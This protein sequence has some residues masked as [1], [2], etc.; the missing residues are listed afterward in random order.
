MPLR[1]GYEWFTM[2]MTGDLQGCWYTRSEPIPEIKDNEQPSGIYQ[3]R[4]EEMFVEYEY[5][6]DDNWKPTDNTFKTTYFFNSKYDPEFYIKNEE[7][8]VVDYG[9]EVHGRCQHP[10]VE[11]SG[12]GRFSGATGWVFFKDDVAAGENPYRGHIKLSNGRVTKPANQITRD[13]CSGGGPFA[14]CPL[15]Y[16]LSLSPVSHFAVYWMTAFC[17]FRGTRARGRYAIPAVLLCLDFSSEA[18]LVR[19]YRGGLSHRPRQP[20]IAGP[21]CYIALLDRF[22]ICVTSVIPSIP[23]GKR[24]IDGIYSHGCRRT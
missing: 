2:V 13:P 10:I 20:S 9:V 11:G 7:G 17:V 4:G 24:S 3:E 16:S 23:C 18:S 12:T 6:D 19:P 21:S 15:D 5:D 22:R 14:F 1:T 8:E